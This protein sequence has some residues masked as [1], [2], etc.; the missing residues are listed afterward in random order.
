MG[1]QRPHHPELP[2]LGSVGRA[3]RQTK[4]LRD[5]FS[6]L[7]RNGFGDVVDVLRSGRRAS[8]PAESAE[9]ADGAGPP[10][11][12]PARI[13]RVLEELGPTFVKLGQIL[14]TRS[15]L[16]PPNLLEE[17]SK[18]QDEVPPFPF[19][20]V[21]RVVEQEFG[22]PLEEVFDS[23]DKEVLAS[24]SLGQVH[25]ARLGGQAVAVKVQRPGIQGT[26]DTDL[27]LMMQF[28]SALERHVEGWDIHQPTRVVEEFAKT[29]EQELDYQVEAAHQESFRR[30]FASDDTVFVPAVLRE[31]TT[32]RVLTMEF[33]NGIKVTDLEALE[34][35]G[36]DPGELA[37]RGFQSVLRQTLGD[38]FFHADPHPGNIFVLPG[39]Q[40]CFIDFGMM[41]RL[42]QRVRDDFVELI[43]H[44]VNRNS[45]RVTATILRLTRQRTPVDSA[46]VE[47]DVAEFI[48]GQ[49][50]QPLEEMD[51][52]HL[53]TQVLDSLA[54]YGLRVP[55]DLY[56]MLK[57]IAEI[58]SLAVRLDPDFDIVA[59]GGPYVRS[60]FVDRFRPGRMAE[61]L[62]TT[63]R[64]L[65]GVL[66]DAPDLLRDLSDRARTGSLTKP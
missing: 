3:V 11:A 36:A 18:L 61:E 60:L 62:S 9:H 66:R 50:G 1:S 15:D 49:V 46:A 25:K 20:E 2:L 42:S 28:A 45:P 27:E 22:R 12:R 19:E 17:L 6:V 56:L 53:L 63:A 33:V 30:R 59:E 29:L 24:G 51:V 54:R 55:A 26:I 35:A 47:R 58:E 39:N 34:A 16:V 48:D 21:Q 31:A 5:V 64:E 32:R 14:S 10:Q 52:G 8:L 43:Y 40:V 23:F 4:R 44:I 7:I 13:R 37:R 38:G 65:A 41:G 57:A